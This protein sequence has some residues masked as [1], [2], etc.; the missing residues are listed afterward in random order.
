QYPGFGAFF[1]PKTV[2]FEKPVLT[3]HFKLQTANS[4]KQFSSKLKLRPIAQPYKSFNSS[5][6]YLGCY[7]LRRDF[8]AADTIMPHFSEAAS[9]NESTCTDACRSWGLPYAMYRAGADSGEQHHRLM[10]CLW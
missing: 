8:T 1:T 6:S 3:S 9:E 4:G 5:D 10:F 2:L 7:Y